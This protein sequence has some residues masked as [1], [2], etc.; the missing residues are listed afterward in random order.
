MVIS[1]SSTFQNQYAVI[2]SAI[3]ALQ[4]QEV[5]GLVTLGPA[6]EKD[7]FTVPENVIV[8]DSAPHS[9]VFP[10]ADLV[11]THAGHGT[12]M[13]ALSHGLPLVCL[14]MGRDQHD[15]AIKVQ[16]HGCGIALS[17]KASPEKIRKAVHEILNKE[18]FK[19]AVNSF[20]EE[21]QSNNQGTPLLRE[22]EKIIGPKNET[23]VSL[24]EVSA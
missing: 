13:R 23:K 16:H 4:G 2:Q 7:R 1:L 14:P 10:L 19:L 24:E 3:D 15:N 20:K 8:M 17:A 22:I 5:R 18:A 21:I 11:I 12:V 6:V 9:Q